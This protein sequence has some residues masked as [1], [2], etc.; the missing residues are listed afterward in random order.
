[1]ASAHISPDPRAFEG[2]VAKCRPHTFA[3][4]AAV[5]YSLGHEATRPDQISI[6]FDFDDLSLLGVMRNIGWF[7][8]LANDRHFLMTITTFDTTQVVELRP[9][10][11]RML[12][13]SARATKVLS[14]GDLSGY[15]TEGLEEILVLDINLDPVTTASWP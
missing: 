8:T 9:E 13:D 12:F 3:E 10:G 2:L 4:L 1:M 15:A 11:L 14:L 7:H 6:N 5:A